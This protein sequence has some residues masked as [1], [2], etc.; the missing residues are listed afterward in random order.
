[1]SIS[2]I[3]DIHAA[4]YN[5]KGNSVLKSFISNAK[6]NQ[7]KHIILLGDIFDFMVGNYN[8][9]YKEWSEFFDWLK[10]QSH[11]SDI[12][13]VEGNHDFHLEKFFKMNFPKVMYHKCGFEIK[14]NDQNFYFEHG[15][16]LEL[17]NYSYKR[18]KKIIRSKFVNMIA[19]PNYIS[20]ETAK[21]I[22]I[23]ASLRTKD[24][25]SKYIKEEPLEVVEK[26]RVSALM[27]MRKRNVEY[28]VCGH[29]H[30][31]DRFESNGVTY[32]NNG[33]APA[34]Q[35]FI[36]FDGQSIDFENLN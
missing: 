14:V 2:I 13:F 16:D 19:N 8:E 1:M 35:S 24:I 20:F 18:Y 21:K 31:K 30:I 36:Y 7:S 10:R 11:I 9:Y 34:S 26:F 33:Y 25:D 15:D 4:Q 22:G 32:I 28:I 29:G 6:V 17:N 5:S 23:N 12:H 3:S 27:E